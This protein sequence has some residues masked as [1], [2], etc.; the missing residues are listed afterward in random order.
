M[1][2]LKEWVRCQLIET[3]STQFDSTCS[4]PTVEGPE[5]VDET[6]RSGGVLERIAN[7][8]GKA[9]DLNRLVDVAAMMK[10][11]SLCPLGRFSILPVK[12]TIKHFRDKFIQ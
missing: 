12:S 5:G 4:E 3:R 11:P 10:E 1:N 9:G 6:R 7:G 2:S 8:K